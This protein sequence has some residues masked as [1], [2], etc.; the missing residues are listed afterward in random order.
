MKQWTDWEII[1]HHVSICGRILDTSGKPVPGVHLGIVPHGKQ[2]GSQPGARAR[3]R[4]TTVQQELETEGINAWKET[5]SHPDGTFFFLDCPA[6]EY[7]LKA[8]DTRS[9]VQTQ[10]IVRTNESAMKKRVKDR[11]SDEGY[12][13]E[14]VLK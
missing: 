5:E 14:L 2:S 4:A 10:Q 12:Q 3:G 7:T 6:G 11:K 1:R 13:I 9:G 8:M